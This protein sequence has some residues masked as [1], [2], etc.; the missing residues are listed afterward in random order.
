MSRKPGLTIWPCTSITRASGGGGRSGPTARIRPSSIATS[1][2]ASRSWARSMT[3]PRRSSRFALISSSP[4]GPGG[5]GR[6]YQP[7]GSGEANLQDAVRHPRR[8][9]AGGVAATV[10][11]A[12]V[13]QAEHISMERALQRLA[14]HPAGRQVALLVGTP[15]IHG[16]VAVAEPD[17]DERQ[18][19]DLDRADRAGGDLLRRQHSMPL[20]CRRGWWRLA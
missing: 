5:T 17:H 3:R 20:G 9:E 1:A 14:Q 16:E 7:A 19:A 13:L 8:V 11:A 2:T 18:A 10:Q 15:A 12:T 4:R 6:P